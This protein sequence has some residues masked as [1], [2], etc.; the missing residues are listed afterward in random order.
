MEA[1]NNFFSCSWGDH[2]GCCLECWKCSPCCG[3]P[4]DPCHA[5][6]CFLCFCTPA[7]LITWPF[8]CAEDLD[9]NCAIGNHFLPFCIIN[10]LLAGILPCTVWSCLRHNRRIK[11]NSDMK[12]GC[13]NKIGDII[14]TCP[15]CLPFALCHMC[16]SMERDQWN[17]PKKCAKKPCCEICVCPF[18]MDASN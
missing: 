15:P 16:R 10:I 13:P 9:Q 17:W 11:Y 4:W 7:A 3:D 6:Y 18:R 5:I 8:I 14:M 2:A 1:I 12:P